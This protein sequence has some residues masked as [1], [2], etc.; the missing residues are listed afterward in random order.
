[1]K[2]DLNP[3]SIGLI[4]VMLKKGTPCLGQYNWQLKNQTNTIG[5]IHYHQ[6]FAVGLFSCQINSDVFHFWIEKFL[7]PE[8]PVSSVI[9][10]DNATFHWF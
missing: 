9:V 1:M 8:L 6:L 3:M 5:T 2:V 4:I 7:I 10:M